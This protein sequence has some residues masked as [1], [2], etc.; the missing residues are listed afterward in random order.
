MRR[1]NTLSTRAIPTLAF[2]G[3]L[4][5]CVVSKALA[6]SNLIAS[7]LSCERI[8]SDHIR[9]RKPVDRRKLDEFLFDAARHGCTPLAKKFLGLGASTKAR[10]RLGN[11]VLSVAAR[12]GHRTTVK[13]LIEQGSDVNHRNLLGSSVLL[14]AV[15]QRRRAVMRL[16]LKHGV[17][18]RAANRR[19]VTP[20]IAA[21]FN[22]D[23]RSVKIL[24]A[25]GARPEHQDA[26]GKGAIVY[27]AARGFTPLVNLF[28]DAGLDVNKVY[29][30]DLTVLM[31]AAGHSNDVPE[32]DGLAT[33]RL[34]LDQGAQV[35]AAD[36]RG[37]TALMIAAERGHAKIAQVLLQSGAKRSRRDK[38]GQTAYNLATNDKLRSILAAK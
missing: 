27:A 19:G 8:Q 29:G 15:R 2:A 6:Q 7:K 35:D 28:L 31:W 32:D 38:K 37:R 1:A 21:A 18:A 11:T 3:L 10:D 36:N 33:V 26:T 5:T 20:L 16:L 34:L 12:M 23:I 13:M 14:R 17:D 4:A 24:L 30:N 22:G 25:A 9:A